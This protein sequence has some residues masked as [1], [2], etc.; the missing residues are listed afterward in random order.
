[1]LHNFF[2]KIRLLFKSHVTFGVSQLEQDAYQGTRREG[3]KGH[4]FFTLEHDDGATEEWHIPNVVTRDMSLLLARLVVN[5]LAPRHGIYAL[6]IGSGDTGW[7]LQNPPAE[8]NTQ[9]ALYSE[10]ARKT[11]STT[12][13]VDSG[14]NPVTYPTNIIDL[15]TTYAQSEA[16]GPLVEMGLIGGDVNEDLSLTNPVT[17]SNGAYDDTVDVTGTDTLCNYLTF[18]V[19]NK[20]AT[21][22]L[23]I[24]WRLTF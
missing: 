7:D 21:S 24:V 9:R 12:T 1:M 17:P 6:A 15:T 10:L 20:P 11:F 3:V 23:T 8:T 14:G 22:R 2:E 18:P 13:F 4:V 19:I 5:P 16:V